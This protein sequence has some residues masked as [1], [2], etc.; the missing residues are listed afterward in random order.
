M[1]ITFVCTADMLGY[2]LRIQNDLENSKY[3][4]GENEEK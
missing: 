4:P 1:P 2:I 3:S